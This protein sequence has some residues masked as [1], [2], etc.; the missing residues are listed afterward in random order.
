MV[1]PF[2]PD[3][4]VSRDMLRRPIP[5]QPAHCP[6]SVRLNRILTHEIS[7]DFRGGG[8]LFLPPTANSPEFIGSHNN[9]CIPMAFTAE[10]PQAQGQ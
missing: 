1:S 3:N 6:H 5:C 7:P 4:L 9:N 2:A 10:S 8:H